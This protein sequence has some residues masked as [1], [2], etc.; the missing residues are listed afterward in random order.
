MWG[1][2]EDRTNGI[3]ENGKEGQS[4]LFITFYFDRVPG[5]GIKPVGGLSTEGCCDLFSLFL[6]SF[7]IPK[8]LWIHDS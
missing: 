6:A 7:S 1:H 8:I 3:D 5:N 2:Y 4:P